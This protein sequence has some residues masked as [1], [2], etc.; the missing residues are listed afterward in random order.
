MTDQQPP[1]PPPYGQYPPQAP[2]QSRGGGCGKAALIALAAIGGLVVLVVV[3]TIV[4]VAS[5]DDDDGDTATGSGVETESGNTENPPQDDVTL[6]TC[7][8]APT[9]GLTTARGSILNHS[10][11]T[12]TY[13]IEV[14]VLDPAGTVIGNGIASVANVPAGGTATWEAPTASTHA[15]GVTCDL[16]EVNRV[17][18]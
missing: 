3:I 18:S 7:E 13:F 6:E 5:S 9:V 11:E 8:A 17:A 16:A 1:P 10:S 15:E 2:P 12:S 14:N 4:A